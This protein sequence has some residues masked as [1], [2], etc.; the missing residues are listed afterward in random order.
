MEIL[1]H[2]ASDPRGSLTAVSDE[3]TPAVDE[4]AEPGIRV[5]ER[6]EVMLAGLHVEILAGKSAEPAEVVGD[7]VLAENVVVE[8]DAEIAGEAGD[9]SELEI[10]LLFHDSMAVGQNFRLEL[11][12]KG[13]M[14]VPLRSS[15]PRTRSRSRPGRPRRAV[16]RGRGGGR[17]GR[18]I[19]GKWACRMAAKKRKR[20]REGRAEEEAGKWA[21]NEGPR[22]E[23]RQP[24]G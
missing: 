18:R 23:K 6:H 21:E 20:K 16:P 4:A 12:E 2:Y 3:H 14:E 5:F 1:R 24:I 13:E 8:N 7:G 19:G 11:R 22:E 17:R 10:G 9:A 15:G